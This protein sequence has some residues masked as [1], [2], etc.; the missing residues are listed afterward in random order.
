MTQLDR[1]Q[2][3]ALNKI[4]ELRYTLPEIHTLANGITAYCIDVAEQDLVRVDLL[5]NAGEWYQSFPLQASATVQML[6]EGSALFTSAEIADKLDFYGSFAFFNTQKHTATVTV[7][8]LGKYLDKTLELL[9]DLLLNPTFPEKEFGIMISQ[10]HQQ[11]KVDGE[12][13]ESVAAKQFMKC[14]FGPNHPYGRQI[15][16]SDF[17]NLTI[18]DLKKYHKQYYCSDNCR[19]IISGKVTDTTLNTVS[20]HFGDQPWGKN[21]IPAGPDF[22]VAPQAVLQIYKERES[23]VQTALRIGLPVVNK[24]HPDSR[25]P[26]GKSNQPLR[27]RKTLNRKIP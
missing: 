19:V 4:A 22:T 10:K 21:A 27:V 25:K 5:F 15:S 18:K 16:E 24:K 7:Y 8:A 2:A 23:A 11:Y 26:A 6:N 20:K 3:P 1:T 12:K 17:S 9:K 14:L 13:V